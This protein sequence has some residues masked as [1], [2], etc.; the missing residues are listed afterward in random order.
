MAVVF[1][2]QRRG[3]GGGEVMQRLAV[4]FPEVNLVDVENAVHRSYEQFT[5]QPVRDFVPVL[6]RGWPATRCS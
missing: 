3:Q 1:G 5:G 2:I 4:S 6:S